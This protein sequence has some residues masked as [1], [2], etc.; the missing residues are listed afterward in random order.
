MNSETEAFFAY[1]NAFEE[2][3]DADDW[4]LVDRLFD[5]EIAWSVAGL[6]PPVAYFAHGRPA[7][8]AAIK[9]S[10]DHF[11]RRFDRRAPALTGGPVAIPGGVHIRWCVTYTRDDLPPFKL[12]GEEWDL[13]RD[14]KLAMHH[15]LI[16][17]P[18]E[19]GEFLSRYERELLPPR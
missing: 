10:V 11:D 7:V 6:P 1:A 5:A 18:G 12:L 17:N 4:T 2:A 15:E 3:F 8:S 19:L 16:H 13:F 14:G 9:Q